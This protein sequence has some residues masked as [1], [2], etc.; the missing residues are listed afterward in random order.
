[1]PPTTVLL[2]D[3]DP[4]YRENV[5]GLLEAKGFVVQT[6][7]DGVDALLAIRANRP[8]IVVLAVFLP[9][10]D[11]GR[12]CRL[13]R[14]DRRVRHTAVIAV[15]PLSLEDTK[16]FPE[17][18]ADAFVAKR[19]WKDTGQ[20]IVDA[21]AY[22]AKGEIGLGS[23]IFGFQRFRALRLPADLLLSRRHY[24]TLL[25]GLSCG[26]LEL[27]INGRILMAN[28]RAADLLQDRESNLIG[29]LLQ[30]HLPEDERDAFDEATR[31]AAKSTASEA[32]RIPVTIGSAVLSLNLF[33]SIDGGRC[34]GF[35][36]MIE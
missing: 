8:D 27:D 17:L 9:K 7:C 28:A 11:G 34:L 20:D 4:Q 19:A 13:I 32:H 5:A 10:I 31:I 16:R 36:V 3:D 12:V 30:E 25:R 18:N 33:S 21:I 2:A 29:D 6:A 24:E 22:L 23:G 1:M 26:V 35:L 14:Q 15:S